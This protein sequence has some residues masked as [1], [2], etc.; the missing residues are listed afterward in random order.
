LAGTGVTANTLHPGVVA[1]NF[2]KNNGGLIRIAMSV[3]HL[4]A[5]SPE[6]GAQTSIYL[7]TSPEVEGVT[8]EYFKDRKRVRSSALSYDETVARRLW[9]VSSELVGTKG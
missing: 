6:R 5:I 1:T 4:F 3:F 2:G 8:G 9:D 7:A